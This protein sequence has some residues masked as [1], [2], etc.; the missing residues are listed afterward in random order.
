MNQKITRRHALFSLAAL[1]ASAVLRPASV[2]AAP[3]KDKVRFAILGDWGTGD[4][5]ESGIA[6][7]MVSAYQRTPY[8]F[9]IAAGDNIYPNGSPRHFRK[10]FEQP[11]SRLLDERLKFYAVLGNHDVE[12]G[13]HE[14]CDYPLFNMTGRCYYTLRQGDGLVE[15]FMLDSTD[16]DGAQASWLERE[17]Q[18]SQAKWK[19]AVFHHPIYSSGKTH[20]SAK[21]LRKVL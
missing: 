1:G 2:F 8:D 18:S 7:E 21:G 6:A 10:N 3:V 4:S 15:F 12:Q 20:G 17:L 5:D 16:F 9:I 14:Q 19:I 11:F 13:R